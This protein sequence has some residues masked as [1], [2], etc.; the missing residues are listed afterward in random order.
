VHVDSLKAVELE[1]DKFKQRVKQIGTM[2]ILVWRLIL[3]KF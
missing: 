3:T 2:K 1:R